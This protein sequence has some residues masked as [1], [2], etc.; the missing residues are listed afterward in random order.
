VPVIRESVFAA[1][2]AGAEIERRRA[3]LIEVV[4]ADVKDPAARQELARVVSMQFDN[5]ERSV[6]LGLGIGPA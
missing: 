1:R 5:D 3:E 6:A 4:T 2:D